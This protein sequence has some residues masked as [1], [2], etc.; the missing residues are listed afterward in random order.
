MCQPNA[1]TQNWHAF[2]SSKHF[3]RMKTLMSIPTF[4]ISLQNVA[5]NWRHSNMICIPNI[6]KSL[7][8]KFSFEIIFK[9]FQCCPVGSLNIPNTSPTQSFP[10]RP[11]FIIQSLWH[12]MFT[13]Y[14][15][16]TWGPQSLFGSCPLILFGGQMYWLLYHIHKECKLSAGH[17]LML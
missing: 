2:W 10:D 13:F 5:H 9:C 3:A 15:T 12:E 4:R 8:L 7:F 17:E 11:I 6:W 1:N 14:S 16:R